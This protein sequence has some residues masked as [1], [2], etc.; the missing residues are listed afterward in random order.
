MMIRQMACLG[1]A[2]AAVMSLLEPTDANAQTTEPA[3]W[4]RARSGEGAGT[5]HQSSA[6]RTGAVRSGRPGAAGDRDQ[7]AAF[8]R[9]GRFDL[10]DATR[11]MKQL[12]FYFV[13]P[14]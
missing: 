12:L 13:A 9:V 7:R 6:L 11:K 10:L 14:S 5:Q 3:A 8:L 2:L 1:W 4:R